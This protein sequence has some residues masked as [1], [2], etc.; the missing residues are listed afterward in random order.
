[1]TLSED[2]IK[3]VVDLKD[4]VL[5]V[6]LSI[7]SVILFGK[8]CKSADRLEVWHAALTSLPFAS[9]QKLPEVSATR[10]NISGRTIL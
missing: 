9:I 5:R 6:P 4:V 7:S 1:M 10:S 3:V 2:A 8:F